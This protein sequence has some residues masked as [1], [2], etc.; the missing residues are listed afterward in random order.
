MDA[1]GVNVER[2]DAKEPQRVTFAQAEKLIQQLREQG[3]LEFAS[4]NHTAAVRNT[5]LQAEPLALTA[6]QKRIVFLP[7]S[8]DLAEAIGRIARFLEG[9]R[10]RVRA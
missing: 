1:D 10:R 6:D 7:N 3:E 2:L 4:L 8:D 9:Y 5:V